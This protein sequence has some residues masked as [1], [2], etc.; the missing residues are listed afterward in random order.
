MIDKLKTL[1][2]LNATEAQIKVF[3]PEYSDKHRSV[4]EEFVK[5]RRV[6]FRSSPDSSWSPVSKETSFSSR[7]EYEIVNDM[8]SHLGK[9]IHKPIINPIGRA[10]YRSPGGDVISSDPQS[11]SGN[12]ADHLSKFGVWDNT[13]D[14]Q[15]S[16]DVINSVLEKEIGFLY[17]QYGYTR[18]QINI[19]TDRDVRTVEELEA[20]FPG[21]DNLHHRNMLDLVRDGGRVL[22]KQTGR[23]IG[24]SSNNSFDFEKYTYSTYAEFTSFMGSSI[25]RPFMSEPYPNQEVFIRSYRGDVEKHT[26]QGN[27]N[28]LKYGA[29]RT[30]YDAEQAISVINEKLSIKYD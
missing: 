24:P 16:I 17:L 12:T 3:L 7:F 19:L 22:E 23:L 25:P 28:I 6:R 13:S 5:G 29:W 20:F 26:Y 1:L 14:A 18:R 9:E 4:A 8:I 15:Q 10:Y 27:K 21:L 30:H 11:I 2:D